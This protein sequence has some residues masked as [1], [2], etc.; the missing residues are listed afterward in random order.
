LKNSIDDDDDEHL[1]H[2]D[3]DT[4]ESV[5]NDDDY[6][7]AVKNIITINHDIMNT[8]TNK[9]RRNKGVDKNSYNIDADYGDDDDDDNQCIRVSHLLCIIR[10]EW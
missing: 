7:Y 2:Y 3:Y 1:D 4:S 5:D 10:Y 8:K 9:R 6:G